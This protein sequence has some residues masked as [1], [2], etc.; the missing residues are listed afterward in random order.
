MT[1]VSES[2][3][4]L[5]WMW[6]IPGVCSPLAPIM[7]L[8]VMKDGRRFIP[9][10]VVPP[11]GIRS[12][13]AG[14]ERYVSLQ[15]VPEDLALAKRVCSWHLNCRSAFPRSKRGLTFEDEFDAQMISEN[16]AAAA[17]FLAPRE[18]EVERAFQQV[19][20]A[21]LHLGR[22]LLVRVTGEGGPSVGWLASN[23]EPYDVVR[24][25]RSGLGYERLQVTRDCLGEDGSNEFLRARRWRLAEHKRNLRIWSPEQVAEQRAAL[26]A[27]LLKKQ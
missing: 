7:L 9:T 17:R 3:Q 6:C 16:V 19:A 11:M 21:D 13:I 1:K 12:A 24:D 15:A 2:S 8:C 26:A 10:S 27:I 25:A 18:H 23:S 4:S 20:P 22:S 14:R 5:Q